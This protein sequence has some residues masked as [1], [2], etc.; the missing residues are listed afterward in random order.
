MLFNWLPNRIAMHKILILEFRSTPGFPLW[1]GK[2][3]SMKKKACR[4]VCSPLWSRSPL[5][6]SR[7]TPL[8]SWWG[9]AP[10]L[11]VATKGTPSQIQSNSCSRTVY[12]RKINLCNFSY[13]FLSYQVQT[14][15]AVFIEDMNPCSINRLGVLHHKKRIS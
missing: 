14:E 2:L 3:N 15:G 12:F 4:L 5:H 1:I 7:G 6:T 10:P 8:S 11:V 9:S 13:S